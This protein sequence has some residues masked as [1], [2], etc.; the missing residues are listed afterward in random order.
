MQISHL[1]LSIDK[2]WGETEQLRQTIEK[3]REEGVEVYSDEYPY[4]AASTGLSVFFPAWSLA[5]GK[6]REH[7]QNPE[8]RERLKQEMFHFG[9]LK[10]YRERD[11]LAAVQIA[12]CRGNPEFEGKTLRDILIERGDEPSLENGAELVM[13]MQSQGGASCVYFLM[14][15]DDVAAIMNFPFNMI[16][17]DGS[18]IRFERGVP[19]PRSYGTFPRVLGKYVRE[20]RRLTLEEAIHKMTALPA[21]S[22]R[23]KD[24]GLLAEQKQAD[25]VIFDPETI[26]DLATFEKPHQ[27]PLGVFTVIVNGVVTVEDGKLTD[28]RGGRAIYGP[29]KIISE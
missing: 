13:E 16:G 15:E 1:K 26:D 22:L 19:H 6:L 7:L 5:D 28:T 10:T 11:M 29:G 17:S 24:R 20:E 27:Y 2:L 14:D 25:L 18:V 23:F 21:K 3:A 9:R 8:M 12:S 4:I